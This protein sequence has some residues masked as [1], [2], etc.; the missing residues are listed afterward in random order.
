MRSYHVHVHVG[1]LVN[2]QLKT[3]PAGIGIGT[4]WNTTVNG[5]VNSGS[6]FMWLHTH[7]NS[8]IVH[9]EAPSPQ[10]F[11][12]GQFFDIW[13]QSLTSKEV[14]G[15]KGDVT[16]YINQVKF[17]G[18]PRNVSLSNHESISLIIGSVT[19]PPKNFDFNVAGL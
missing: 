9:I 14:V 17:T 3:I 12:L 4:P 7:D 11:T 15:Q 1:S 16:V 19:T 2:G 8:G 18:D 6:C 13:G 10:T 5:F